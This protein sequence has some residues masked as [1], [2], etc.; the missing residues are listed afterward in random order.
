MDFKEK[1]WISAKWLA[2]KPVSDNVVLTDHFR[3][4]PQMVSFFI[5][6][7]IVIIEQQSSKVSALWRHTNSHFPLQQQRS[8]SKL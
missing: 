2:L 7:I 8:E 1:H 5:I 6:I 3:A 4:K